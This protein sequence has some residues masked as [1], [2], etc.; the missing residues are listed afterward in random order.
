[1]EKEKEIDPTTSL[2]AKLCAVLSECENLP[3]NGKNAFHGYR[4][5]READVLDHL[6]GLF[7]K[8]GVFCVSSVEDVQTQERKNQKGNAE[9]LTRVK[10][11]YSLLNAS[12]PD[13]RHDVIQYGDGTDSGDKG[14]YKA[15]SGAMKYFLSKTFLIGGDDDPENE[16]AETRGQGRPPS[17]PERR[18]VK[19]RTKETLDRGTGEI[20]SDPARLRAETEVARQ[21]GQAFRYEISL[22]DL[23]PEER[24]A[25]L[26]KKLKELGSVSDTT[27][28]YT[29]TPVPELEELEGKQAAGRDEKNGHVDYDL[30]DL[31][32]WDHAEMDKP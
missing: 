24:K 28:I 32:D 30:D 27:Y 11:K 29:T 18:I 25:P 16:R 10:I 13:E 14:L 17:T 6:R 19:L 7:A 23:L 9:Y 31:P 8:H 5:V 2:A 1:M 15:L 21:S 26:R 12:N 20:K 22:T 3:K 4:Y